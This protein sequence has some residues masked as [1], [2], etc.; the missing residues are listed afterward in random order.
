MSQLLRACLFS[1][2]AA[3][4]VASAQQHTDDH[5]KNPVGSEA[6]ASKQDAASAK[7]AAKAAEPKAQID[8]KSAKILPS[9]VRVLIDVSGSMKQTDP[10]NLRK[11]AL[12]LIVRLLP[13]KSRAGVWTFGN[14]VNMLMPLRTVDAAWRK[15]AAPKAQTINSIAMY[16]NIGKGLDEVSFDRKNLSP[17]YKTHIILLTDG[18]VDIGKDALGNSTE[19]KRILTDVLPDLKTAGYRV[20]TIAL[21]ANADMELMKKL[22]VNTD[23]VFTTATSADQLMSVF[24]KIFDQAV[25]AERVPLE[26]NGFMV[27]ASIKEFT[28]LIFRKPGNDKTVLVSPDGKDFSDTSAPD[29]I[30]WYRT[31]KYDLIT[32]SN[33]KAGQWKIKTEIAPESRVTVVSNLQLVVEPLKNNLHMADQLTVSYVF[34]ENGNT[35]TN[36]DFLKLLDATATITKVGGDAGLPQ[37][38]PNNLP[39]DGRYQQTLGN[40]L[41]AGDYEVLLFVDGKTFKREFKHNLSVRDSVF[42]LEKGQARAEDGK[43]T[44]NYKIT[45]DQTLADAKK[46]QV[47][48]IIKGPGDNKMNKALTLQEPN[49]WE[50]NFTPLQPGDYTIEIQGQGEA[51]DSSQFDETTRADSFT[52]AGQTSSSAEAKPD[53]PEEQHEEKVDEHPVDGPKEDINLLL[54]AS[55]ALGNL[56]LI[57]VGYFAYKKLLGG[58]AKAE[59]NEFEQTLSQAGKKPAPAPGKEKID[60]S[61]EAPRDIPMNDDSSMDKL[62]PL[63]NMDD[64]DDDPN[65]R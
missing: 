44:Y 7:P 33:P 37:G 2:I 55:I 56:L 42:S 14:S 36:K 13:D 32:A 43:T 53:E 22:S 15:E 26:N 27:D 60:L 51:L 58:G 25:P 39:D 46:V 29:N 12:D 21:S 50:F 1:L 64:P 49:R 63:D 8:S 19:R 31:D 57:G 17:D 52:L 18:V 28:A 41:E 61:A 11:P 59:L 24:L 9:D 47:N 23:G 54:Y 4:C 35:I 3:S 16:T 34:Q 48:A 20:H 30:N 5:G 38:F 45:L 6:A 10:Q 40:F 62:F 65:N